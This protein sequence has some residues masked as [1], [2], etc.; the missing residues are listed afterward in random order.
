V[1]TSIQIAILENHQTIVDGYRFRLPPPEFEIVGAAEVYAD[2]EPLLAGQRVD[3]ALMDVRVPQQRGSPDTYPILRVIPQLIQTYPE[4]A[5]LVVSAYLEPT[6][7]LGVI[8]AGA[9]GFIH[10]EDSVLLQDLANV[11]RSIVSSRG[12]YLSPAAKELWV[13]R[14]K[15]RDDGGLTPRQIEALTLCA[16]DPEA[17]TP[18]VARQMGI[19][20]STVRNLLSKAYLRL[21]VTTRMAAVLKAKEMGL[22]V[23]PE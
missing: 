1:P 9:N 21:G 13:Q 10:K 3:L 4:M 11:V 2:W 15:R 12:I 7:V 17:S 20:A 16:A 19:S 6:L 14:Q 8:E 22:I 18:D 23:T 5:I